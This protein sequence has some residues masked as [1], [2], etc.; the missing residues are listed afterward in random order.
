MDPRIIY[1][2][3][4]AVLTALVLFLNAKYGM[5]RDE[6]I[7]DKKKPYSYART[8]LTWWTVIVLSGFVTIILKRFEIP[9]FNQN[10]L[11][12]LGISSATTI[13]AR[14]TDISDKARTEA[15]GLSQNSPGQ[16]F[17]VDILSD[18]NGVS[19]HRLQA[20]IFN[21]VIGFWFIHQTLSN[22]VAAP[23]IGMDKILPDLNPN[24]L[25]LM[26]LSA[27][28]YAALKMTENKSTS[29]NGSDK[30]TANAKENSENNIPPL[31]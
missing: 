10:V 16:N 28:T 29:G 22:L 15:E 24:N 1:W 3:V 30:N 9:T 23:A 13:T 7:L 8:Q 4:L 11:I 14:L 26:G 19:I 5:L 25:I 31:A 2:L 21:I 20:V 18:N 27:G 12:L 17:V 6:S